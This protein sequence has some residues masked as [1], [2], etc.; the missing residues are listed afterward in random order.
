MIIQFDDIT[1][2]AIEESDLELIREMINDPEIEKMT[3][4]GGFPVSAYQQ[5]RW[6]ESIQNRNNELRLMI[7]TNNHG[8]IGLV[9]LTD[10][11]YKNGT[12][13]FHYKLASSKNLRGKG[14]GTKALSALV[15]YAFMQMN[16]NCIYSGNVEY[17]NVTER[18]KEKLGFKKEGVLRE[19]VFKNGKYFNIHVWSLLRSDW[20]KANQK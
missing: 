12:A 20:V 5:K 6:F 2:R 3:G 11:D 8:T 9:A 4:G 18:I 15:E 1:L 16:L 14:Y 13:E 17:N 7:D 10:I 19:R